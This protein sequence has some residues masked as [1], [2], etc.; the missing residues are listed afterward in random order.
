MVFFKGALYVILA[1]RIAFSFRKAC[2]TQ[3]NA[4]KNLSVAR[5]DARFPSGI[6]LAAVYIFTALSAALMLSFSNAHAQAPHISYTSPQVYTA[7]VAINPLSP[8]NTGGAVPPPTSV[9]IGNYG[10]VT[11]VTVDGSGNIYIANDVANEIIKRT[12]G[13][14]QSIL[15]SP[16]S[17]HGLAV[18]ATGNIYYCKGTTSIYKLPAGSTSSQIVASGLASPWGLA[19]DAAGNLYFSEHAGADV[20]EI[21]TGSTTPVVVATGFKQPSG[22]TVDASGNIYVADENND[23]IKKI[24]AGS[25]MVVSLATA[26]GNA[27]GVAVDSFGNIYF[28]SLG[29]GIL[30]EIPVGGGSSKV[31]D[32][33]F[34]DTESI[35]LDSKGDIFVGNTGNG[36]LQEL[37]AGGY[38]I[39]PLPPAGISLDTRTGVISGTPTVTSPATNYKVIA[40]NSSGSD[41]A[42]VNIKVVAGTNKSLSGLTINHGVLSPAF[43]TATTAYAVSVAN[44]ISTVSLTPTLSNG[45]ATVTINGTAVASG[46]ASAAIPLSIGAN[47][48]QVVVDSA[49]TETDYTVTVTRASSNIANLTALKISKGTLSPAFNSATTSYTSSVAAGVT[50]MT[51]TPTDPTAGT[52]ITVNGTAVASGTASPAINLVAGENTISIVVTASDGT[53][54]K[55][56]TLTVTCPGSTN[57]N[58]SS[59]K[60]SRGTLTPAFTT[61]TTSY[62]ASVVNG[63]TSLTVTPTTSASN[64]TVTVN[65]TA[66]TSGDASG[67][68]ELAVGANTI[69]IVVTAFGGSATK[70]YTIIVT[71]ESGGDDSFENGIS[72]TKPTE[73]PAIADDGVLVHQAVSPNGDGINDFLIIDNINQYPDNKLTILNRNGQMIY[74]ATGYDNSSKVFDGHS[75]KNGQMQLPGTY[76][77]ELDYT[78][79]GITKTKTGFIVLKY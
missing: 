23:A 18:D 65:G 12:A 49:T 41:T 30:T 32:S 6:N 37:P 42:V 24:V 2:S 62:T 51:V 36:L 46:S 67:P 3:I 15:V 60:I 71:R 21:P 73:T 68:I 16:V 43:N 34:Y 27:N 79:K 50:S 52:S 47:P 53:T 28:V 29:R 56:Y 57:D 48:I 54:T 5:N 17:S 78:V 55:T 74:Q 44:G 10:E 58:L 33:S 64:A 25:G 75:N 39:N 9:T 70:T 26:V 61:N 77:Y 11:A 66:V 22:I 31:V 13:G 20:K 72:V 19:L 7:G 59:L 45:V 40:T 1:L 38:K 69:T 76:F 63:V 35:A 4:M 14:E 8:T